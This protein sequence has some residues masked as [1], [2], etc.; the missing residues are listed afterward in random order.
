M[1]QFV[2]DVKAK[3]HGVRL[4]GFGHRV[5]KNYDPRAR[6]MKKLCAE[7]LSGMGVQDSLLEVA[8]ELER[9]ACSGGAEAGEGAEGAQLRRGEGEPC[10]SGPW[11]SPLGLGALLGR[12]SAKR[13]GLAT[14]GRRSAGRTPGAGLA[15]IEGRSA[16]MPWPRGGELACSRGPP[17]VHKEGLGCAGSHTG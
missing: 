11:V 8:Q 4:M 15:S 6:Y 3:K 17:S 1:A 7:V 14:A 9:S 12:E 10:R 5:Y 13:C 16:R 2:A